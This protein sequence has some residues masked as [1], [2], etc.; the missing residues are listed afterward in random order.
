M[1]RNNV[2]TSHGIS[3]GPAVEWGMNADGNNLHLPYL[4]VFLFSPP[5]AL[6]LI[7]RISSVFC[8]LFLLSHTLIQSLSGDG[9]YTYLN[10]VLVPV[11][12]PRQFPC[13]LWFDIKNNSNSCVEFSFSQTS[14]S[15]DIIY[16]IFASTSLLLLGTSSLF[17]RFPVT[18]TASPVFFYIKWMARFICFLVTLVITNFYMDLNFF[19][20]TLYV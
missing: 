8:V 7:I 1:T 2:Y 6:F 11:Q 20:F 5:S 9:L 3:Q 14:V 17:L 13:S 18:R 19:F 10:L 12:F 16:L 15:Q 4:F